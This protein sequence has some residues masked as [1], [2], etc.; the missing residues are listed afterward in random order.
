MCCC[1]LIFCTL[2]VFKFDVIL[3]QN[4][5]SAGKHLCGNMVIR[6]LGYSVCN[7]L[8]THPDTPHGGFMKTQPI[9]PDLRPEISRSNAKK[10]Q[11]LGSCSSLCSHSAQKEEFQSVIWP[12]ERDRPP[13][14]HLPAALAPHRAQLRHARTLRGNAASSDPQQGLYLTWRSARRIRS[15]AEVWTSPPVSS[16][17]AAGRAG[18]WTPRPTRNCR[19]PGGGSTGA[20]RW[21]PSCWA[22]RRTERRRLRPRCSSCQV[23]EKGVRHGGADGPSAQL[24]L[25]RSAGAHGAA[26]RLEVEPP[27]SQRAPGPKV[28]F[29]PEGLDRSP[30]EYDR[31]VA[32][33]V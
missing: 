23:W 28:A 27:S 9:F 5:I 19:S 7:Y 12:K 26:A 20:H 6:H 4:N 11:W 2:L 14:P 3:A 30:P 18:L 15:D 25:R 8:I 16:E 31:A 21:S 24:R 17:P 33:C 32:P 1:F 22:V 13:V 29:F 10:A